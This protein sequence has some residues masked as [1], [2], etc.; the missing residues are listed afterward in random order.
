MLTERG[1]LG[2]GERALLADG[3]QDSGDAGDCGGQ[4][5]V[6]VDI[7]VSRYLGLRALQELR[8]EGLGVGEQP[9]DQ[10]ASYGLRR[11]VAGS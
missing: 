2:I 4:Q 9:G 1:Q 3:G 6:A 10:V 7:A 8:G 5:V 11:V